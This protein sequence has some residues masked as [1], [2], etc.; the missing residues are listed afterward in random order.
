MPAQRSL[1]S[2]TLISLPLP[3]TILAVGT[4]G[5]AWASSNAPRPDPTGTSSGSSTSQTTD[6][7]PYVTTV[8]SDRKVA[9]YWTPKRMR[10]ARPAEMPVLGAP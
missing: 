9:E 3:A 7:T 1:L 4:I 10:D 5:M 6:N 8:R 2:R